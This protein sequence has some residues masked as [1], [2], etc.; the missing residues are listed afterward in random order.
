[1]ELMNMDMEIDFGNIKVGGKLEIV[2]KKIFNKINEKRYGE[3][4][5]RNYKVKENGIVGI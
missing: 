1:M 5:M 2:R 3:L 4:I